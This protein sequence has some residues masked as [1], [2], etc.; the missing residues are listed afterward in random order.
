MQPGQ[1]RLSE[2]VA[3]RGRNGEGHGE[4]TALAEGAGRIVGDDRN[5]TVGDEGLDRHRCRRNV[6]ILLDKQEHVDG[7]LG[8]R[9]VQ[10]DQERAADGSWFGPLRHLRLGGCRGR[11]RQSRQHQRE[12]NEGFD[13]RAL[14]AIRIALI[15]DRTAVLGE[16]ECR[17]GWD[18]IADGI[19]DIADGIRDVKLQNK[20]RRMPSVERSTVCTVPSG[21]FLI[22]TVTFSRP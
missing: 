7:S 22:V 11:H 18:L 9:R 19:R 14:G 4:Q 15:A 1:V 13:E 10:A 3:A 5:E 12:W 20:R 16:Q 21:T 6:A 17:C 8:R 2:Q